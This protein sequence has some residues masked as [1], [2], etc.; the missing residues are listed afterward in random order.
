[1]ENTV[2]IL[3]S[4]KL[5]KYYTGFTTNLKKRM[6]FHL[7][8]NSTGKFT[9]RADDWKIYFTINC[10]SKQQ[11]LEIER[12][13]KRMKSKVYIQNLRKHPEISEKLLTKY[14]DS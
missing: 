10:E 8:E 13:I 7:D 12:H 1:M 5:D 3:Y 2:Y 14:K 6:S 11:G 9:S 4:Q